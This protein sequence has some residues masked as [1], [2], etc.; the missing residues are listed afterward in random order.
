MKKKIIAY[1][2]LEQPVLETLKQDFEVQFFK[3]SN[4]TSDPSFLKAL[5]EAEGLIGV[6]F[7]AT[8]ELLDM[9]PN[10]KIISNV[11]VGYNNLDLDE[12]TKR[13]IM[14]TNTPGVLDDTVADMVIGLMLSAARRLPELDRYVKAG[15]WKGSLPTDYYGVDVHHQTLGIIGMGRIGSAIA[16]RAHHGFHMNILYNSRRRKPVVEEKYHAI[17]K[18]LNALLEESDFICLITPLTNETEGMIGKEQFQLMKQSAIFI[19]ASRGKTVVEKDLIEALKKKEIA[20]AGLD[21]FEQEPVDP[22]NELLKMPNVVTLPHIGSSTYE[23][24]LKMSEL[25]A[26]NLKMG[27]LGE[28][29]INLLN[30]EVLHK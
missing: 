28:K 22:N 10:L 21:V 23:T 5:R 11:S 30:E 8:A 26:K 20:A 1:Q 27:L 4:P 13:G 15:M 6:G 7:P 2:R 14:A 16:Q 18:D 9:A 29:P 25:A 12:M 24:E 19:N 3:N 17:Y